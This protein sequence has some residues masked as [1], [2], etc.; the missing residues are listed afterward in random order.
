MSSR[1]IIFN[2][3]I[4]PKE[5]SDVWWQP[6]NSPQPVF[7]PNS[8]QHCNILYYP[9]KTYVW[10]RLH[11]F[12][13]HCHWFLLW[14]SQVICYHKQF[15]NCHI[16]LSLNRMVAVPSLVL[17][18]SRTH[19]QQLWTSGHRSNR[20]EQL[21][22]SNSQKTILVPRREVEFLN[23]L[24]IQQVL[25]DIREVQDKLEKE[26]QI[27]LSAKMICLRKQRKGIRKQN[28]LDGYLMKKHCSD[29]PKI[30]T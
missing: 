23:Q 21:T 7:L 11:I 12:Y 28:G 25:H 8:L 16:F 13:F 10:Q 22:H 29:I 27:I 9:E 20:P 17:Y 18:R 5:S 6:E 30:E 2:R 1:Q 4:C 14:F 3:W 26:P 24:E 19:Y 15:T